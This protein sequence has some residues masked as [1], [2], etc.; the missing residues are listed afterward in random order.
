M[1]VINYIGSIAS[2][3]GK[4]KKETYAKTKIQSVNPIHDSSKERHLKWA[5]EGKCQCCGEPSGEYNGICDPCRY[6]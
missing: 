1:S 4:N 5:K 6:S 2:A 3:V